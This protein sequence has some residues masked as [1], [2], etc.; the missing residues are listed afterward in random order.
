[1]NIRIRDCMT[2]GADGRAAGFARDEV[3]IDA[4]DFLG[5]VG[6]PEGGI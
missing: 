4:G 3:G 5:V 2:I 1:M 6:R